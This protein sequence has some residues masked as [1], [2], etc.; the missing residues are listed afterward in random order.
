MSGQGMK[1]ILARKKYLVVLTPALHCTDAYSG[2]R[3]R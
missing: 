1:Q 2:E 3:N